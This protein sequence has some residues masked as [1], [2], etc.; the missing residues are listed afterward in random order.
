MAVA[1]ATY[2]IV[3]PTYSGFTGGRPVEATVLQVNGPAS[4]IGLLFP[5]LITFVPLLVRKQW[6]RIAAAILT[7]GFSLIGAFTIGLFYLPAA[8]VMLLAGCVTESASR[9]TTV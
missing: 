3:W 9:Y 8:F 1:A 4:L 7:G 2:L 5:V 6:A